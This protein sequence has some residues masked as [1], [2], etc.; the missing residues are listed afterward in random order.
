MWKKN[1]CMKQKQKKQKS[2]RTCVKE[3]LHARLKLF[4]KKYMWKNKQFVWNKKQKK[5]KN[6][7]TCVKEGLHARLKLPWDCAL[8]STNNWHPTSIS[9]NLKKKIFSKIKKNKNCHST[10]ISNNLK[11]H[12]LLNDWVILFSFFQKEIKKWRTRLWQGSAMYVAECCKQV[13]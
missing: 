10:S 9:N 11:K 1:I 6:S 12:L 2:S 13:T 8:Q 4:C 5:Q 7:R 3:G